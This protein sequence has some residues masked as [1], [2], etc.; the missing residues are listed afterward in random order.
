MD[1]R[2]NLPSEIIL[3]KDNIKEINFILSLYF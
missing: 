3:E 2:K 1:N